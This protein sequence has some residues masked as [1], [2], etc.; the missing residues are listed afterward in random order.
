MHSGGK[1]CL[2]AIERVSVDEIC[3]NLY[4]PYQAQSSPILHSCCLFSSPAFPCPPLNSAERSG[5]KSSVS[6]SER[7]ARVP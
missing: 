3:V 5:S 7:L 2:G 1:V 6:G 4:F